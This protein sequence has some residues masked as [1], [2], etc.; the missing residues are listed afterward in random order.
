MVTNAISKTYRY[1]WDEALRANRQD[2][3]AM[4]RDVSLMGMVRERQYPTSQLPWHIEPEDPEDPSQ[5]EVAQDLEKTVLKIPH[6]QRM[7][8]N[9]LE[10]IWYGRYGV[11]VVY[12]PK[13]VA[14]QKRTTVIK[15]VP[16]NGDKI[17]F[18]WDGT[19]SV[20]LHAS[21]IRGFRQRRCV[22]HRSRPGLA[23]E[24]TGMASTVPDPQA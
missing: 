12:G 21:A 8:L 1:T 22:A 23:P 20:F 17:Q 18:Q 3:T 7:M 4:R 10:A 6:L 15:H 19:P 5:M 16:V 9:L 14:G 2:P 13:R 11:Q 24:E